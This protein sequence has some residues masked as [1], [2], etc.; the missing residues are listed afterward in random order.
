MQDRSSR[1][2]LIPNQTA[3]ALAERIITLRRQRLCGRHIAQQT[4][5]APATV[6]RVL[7]PAGGQGRPQG[8]ELIESDT[9]QTPDQ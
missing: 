8:M 9:L 1:P 7:R 4:G 3:Q 5:V 2:K 6:S